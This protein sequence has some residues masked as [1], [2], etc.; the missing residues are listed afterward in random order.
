MKSKQEIKPSL[1]SDLE[2]LGTEDDKSLY[3]HVFNPD[4]SFSKGVL[5]M[6]AQH[7]TSDKKFIKESQKLYKKQFPEKKTE[8]ADVEEIWNEINTETGFYEKYQ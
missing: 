7:Y 2:L 4:D 5:P 8:H 3:E 6:W 1:K